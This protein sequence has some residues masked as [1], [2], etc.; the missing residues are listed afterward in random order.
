MHTS[1]HLIAL[2]YLRYGDMAERIAGAIAQDERGGA[3]NFAR[4]LNR[5]STA[6]ARKV[7]RSLLGVVEARVPPTAG[8]LLFRDALILIGKLR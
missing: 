3:S 6:E 2:A 4:N 1:E 7:C 8:Q 5:L